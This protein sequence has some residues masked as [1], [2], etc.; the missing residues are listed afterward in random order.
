[1]TIKL[2]FYY[3]AERNND[4]VQRFGNHTCLLKSNSSLSHD[5]LPP[6]M[7]FQVT[8]VPASPNITMVESSNRQLFDV[9]LITGFG[10]GADVLY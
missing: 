9:L 2:A 3:E 4:Q 7:P 6:P 10:A 1:M 5:R 8:A